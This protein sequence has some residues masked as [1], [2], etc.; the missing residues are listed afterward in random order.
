[1]EN[2][3][4]VSC[5]TRFTAAIKEDGSLW[6]WGENN[7]G[8]LGNNGGYD[9]RV[10]VMSSVSPCLTTPT[11]VMDNVSAVACGGYY[12]VAAKTDGS[13]WSWGSNISGQLGIGSTVN[14]L[15][16]VKVMDGVALS[17]SAVVPSS[18][19]VAGFSDVHESD[20]YAEAVAWAMDSGITGGTTATTFSPGNTVTRAQAVTFL[21]RAAGSPQPSSLTPPLYRC[22]GPGCLLL[23]SRPVG[24]GAGHHRRRRQQPVR[25]RKDPAL[26]SCDL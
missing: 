12:T 2:V 9:I 17:A 16:P 20:Y 3:T 1:M 6:T 11:K 19:T 18:P 25:P 21:W 14:A 15:T 10:G 4:A 7:Y 13:L 5:G 23:P 26:L 22:D 8:Q 24:G